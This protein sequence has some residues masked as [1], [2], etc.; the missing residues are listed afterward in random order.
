MKKKIIVTSKFNIMTGVRNPAYTKSVEISKTQK[1]IEDRIDIFMNFTAQSLMHQTNQDF[2]ALYVYD[3]S[4]KNLIFNALDMYDA[5]PENIMFVSKDE[6]SDTIDKLS[7]GYDYLYISRLDSDDCYVN[8]F[9]Q[10]LHDY[11]IKDDTQELLCQYGYVY[12]SATNTLASYFHEQFTFY[13][14]IY[15]LYSERIKYSSLP[16]TPWDL[17]VN[18]FHFKSVDYIYESLHGNN[19]MF[20]IHNSNTDSSFDSNH[21]SN[22]HINNIIDNPTEKFKILLTFL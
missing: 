12:E 14:F 2:T 5:L 19:F 9:I 13:T 3:P 22:R 7:E 10:T 6:Y 21:Y 20:N 4:T 15:R 8:T 1:W 17:L 16:L 18:F 11:K